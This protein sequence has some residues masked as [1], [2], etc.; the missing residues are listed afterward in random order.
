MED[1]N[2]SHLSKQAV[3][4]RFVPTPVGQQGE[5][6]RIE[7]HAAPQPPRPSYHW[8]TSILVYVWTAYVVSAAITVCEK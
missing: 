2:I 8:N 5:H 4:N 3:G 6:T 7:Y 1:E